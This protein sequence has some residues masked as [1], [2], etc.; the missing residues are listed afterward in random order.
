MVSPIPVV[1]D[2]TG[3]AQVA[4][5]EFTVPPAPNGCVPGTYPITF[6]EANSPFHTFTGFITLQF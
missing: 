1:T 6:T 4:L 2:G 3:R 5:T